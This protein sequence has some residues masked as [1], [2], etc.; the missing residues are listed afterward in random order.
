MKRTIL[1][2]LAVTALLAL[3]VSL[4][5]AQNLP[6]D[7]TPGTVPGLDFLDADGDGVCDNYGDNDH[8]PMNMSR[9]NHTGFVDADGDG[10]CD[11][12]GLNQ[13]GDNFVDADSDGVCDNLG[14]GLQG[15][16]GSNQRQGQGRGRMGQ[17]NAGGQP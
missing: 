8:T 12:A 11:N 1:I 3:G 17:G 10:T 2:T 4:A 7:T 16:N 13:S 5:A 14:T 15:S 9:G 6:T